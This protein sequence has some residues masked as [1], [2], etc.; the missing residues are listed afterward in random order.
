[1]GGGGTEEVRAGS[2]RWCGETIGGA[3]IAMGGRGQGYRRGGG[4]PVRQD[5]GEPA[6]GGGRKNTGNIVLA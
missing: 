2:G 3:T 6:G 1:V 5:G 4:E